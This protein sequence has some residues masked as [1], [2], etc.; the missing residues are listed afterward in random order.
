MSIKFESNISIINL[1]DNILFSIKKR[2][3]I[4]TNNNS[5]TYNI[6]IKEEEYQ[7]L[8]QYLDKNKSD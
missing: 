6:Y 3:I 7:E 8:I 1:L 4:S 5:S 2:K